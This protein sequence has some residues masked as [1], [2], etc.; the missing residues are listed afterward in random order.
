MVLVCLV[1]GLGTYT[2][3]QE[4]TPTDDLG[5]VSDAFQENFFEALKQKGIQNYE[6]ALSALESALTA[7][8]GDAEQQAVVYYEMAKNYFALRQ[9]EPAEQALLES[10]SLIPN[11]FDV[12]E[13]LYEV[14]HKAQEY[15]KAIPI[16]EKLI[17]FDKVYKE[18]LAN[19]YVKTARFDEALA[20]I[21]ELDNAVGRNARRD[22]LRKRIISITG[23][24]GSEITRLEGI[25]DSET[26]TE[27]DFLELIY[28]L[29]TEG[30]T[31]KAEAVA[32]KL[33]ERYP[34]SDLVHLALYKF[35]LAKGDNDS[36]VSSMQQVLSARSIDEA[37]KYKVLAD[38][39]DFTAANPNYNSALEEAIDNFTTSV[40]SAALWKQLGDFF[41]QQN[42][43]TKALEFYEKGIAADSQDYGL[44]KNTLLLQIETQA[45]D[46][47]LEL[48]ETALE[49]YPAQA[50]LYLLKGVSLIGLNNADEAI[51]VLEEGVD[52][53][54]DDPKMEKDFYTQLS[55]AYSAK[56]DSQ[57]AQ[58]YSKKAE[59]L[60]QP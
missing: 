52:Y 42:N 45:F 1:L 46:R 18:D 56:G 43:T 6:K 31:A 57:K 2:H 12:N 25:T 5:N 49:V 24:V 54:I 9:Y 16:V 28:R 30:D 39:M 29:S 58:E 34:D 60:G 53:V 55:R 51:D 27:Q 21:N 8:K 10:E 11:R 36:A 41:L 22:E 44:I 13:L 20:L 35:A 7:A 33:L 50:L 38:F 17:P 37:S 4:E 47:S 14:Y 19:L 26:A 48:S 23:D 32:A 15:E 59:E 40:D 3:A